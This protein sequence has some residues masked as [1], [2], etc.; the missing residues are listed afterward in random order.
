MGIPFAAIV[1]GSLLPGPYGL[2]GQIFHFICWAVPGGEGYTQCIS[3]NFINCNASSKGGAISLEGE[4]Y[5]GDCNFTNNYAPKG[6]SIF[7]WAD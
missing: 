7:I 4:N 5:V 2:I 3:C 6:S 1:I